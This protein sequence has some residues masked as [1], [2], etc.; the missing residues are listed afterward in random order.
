[1]VVAALGAVAL[2][3]GCAPP[4]ETI[5][6]TPRS[7]ASRSTSRTDAAA[8][9]ISATS[10][11]TSDTLSVPTP[12]P[13]I[14]VGPPVRSQFQMDAQHSGRSYYAGPR[15]G[16]WRRSFDS[17]PSVQ[18]D[19]DPDIQASA[20]IGQDGTM[21]VG[22]VSRG[23]LALR[24]PGDG[25][26]LV[27][28]WRFQP[29]GAGGVQSTPAVANDGTLYAAFTTGEGPEDHSTLYAVDA[30]G[31][32]RWSLDL[33]S[34]A[35]ASPTLG[36]DGSVYVITGAGRL[37]AISPTGK[38]LWSAQVGPTVN[39]AP[40]VGLDGTVYVASMDDRLYAVRPSS[41][42]VA[43]T[44]RFGG[45]PGDD[46][47]VS[48]AAPTVGPD[49]TIYVV[50]TNVYALTPDGDLTWL[51]EAERQV[52]GISSSA[53][54]SADGQTLYFG[55]NNGGIYALDASDGVLRW[56]FEVVGSVF[57]SPA[58]DREGVLYT[59]STAGHV[60]AID[61]RT[62]EGLWDLPGPTAAPIWTTPAVTRD[63]TLVVADANGFVRVIGTPR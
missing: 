27:L 48:S 42:E 6:V 1:M 62:G 17:S 38:T 15:A 59:G 12:R 36:G 13:T 25:D 16:A 40:A 57:N 4:P 8:S 50:A 28:V 55:A 3:G 43:W 34:G 2:I 30:S 22:T 54:L 53:A 56:R 63:N 21:Y 7:V 52:A 45:F 26:D 5:V 14:L 23:L 46:G 32:A 41:G 18:D 44:F 61:S 60:F 19:A 9:S 49:G 37:L 58:L 35:P 11:S 31:Q 39:A 20:A 33:G 51:F 24:D 29:P 10:A 47:V